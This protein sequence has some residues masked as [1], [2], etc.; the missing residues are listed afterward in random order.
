MSDHL[1][2]RSPLISQPLKKKLGLFFLSPS[3]EIVVVVVFVINNVGGDVVD[4]VL[5]VNNILMSFY[6]Y[7]S[8]ARKA[9]YV[10]VHSAA[11]FVFLSTKGV[12]L[13]YGMQW[14]T[15]MLL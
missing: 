3:R 2:K 12:Q 1:C 14:K 13:R 4:V 5:Y 8:E 6:W 15:Q 9:R 11:A 7:S 10:S